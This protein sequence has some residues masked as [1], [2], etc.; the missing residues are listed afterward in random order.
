MTEETDIGLVHVQDH[1]SPSGLTHWYYGRPLE[2]RKERLCKQGGSHINSSLLPLA[3]QG[4]IKGELTIHSTWK[5]WMEIQ[6]FPSPP[7]SRQSWIREALP[8][9]LLDSYIAD[10][11]C[12]RHLNGFIPEV[13]C[14][15]VSTNSSAKTNLTKTYIVILVRLCSA[16]TQIYNGFRN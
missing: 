13:T 15:K 5:Q 14:H 8:S 4:Q 9:C 7:L 2:V 1:L 3:G 10:K 6:L 11:A 12:Y 16:K